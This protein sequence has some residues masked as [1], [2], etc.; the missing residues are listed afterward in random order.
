L[1]Q[2]L[3]KA[4]REEAKGKDKKGY[5]RIN[6]KKISGKRKAPGGP[7]VS[8]DSTSIKPRL[9]RVKKRGE[10]GIQKLATAGGTYVKTGEE[11]SQ[12]QHEDRRIWGEANLSTPGEGSFK[13]IE[14]KRG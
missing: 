12:K 13:T 7:I 14:E 4:S 5:K 3:R 6:K 8:S 9:T 2:E 1:H 10:G 11:I